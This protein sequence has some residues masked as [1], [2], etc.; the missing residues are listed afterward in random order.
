MTLNGEPQVVNLDERF[1]VELPFT[2]VCM[3]MGIAGEVHEVE[4]TL[5]ETPVRSM[6]VAN[7]FFG[8]GST[9]IL[10]SEAGVYSD[11]RAFYVYPPRTEAS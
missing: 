10:P 1:E 9:M 2:E 8:S 5:E 4:L 6:V 7:V 3:H 11:A